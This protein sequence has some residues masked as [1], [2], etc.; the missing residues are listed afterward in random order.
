MS[1]EFNNGDAVAFPVPDNVLRGDAGLTKREWFAG[2]ALQ[3]MG[4]MQQSMFV[5]QN[6]ERISE[7]AKQAFAQA[8]AMI[9]AGEVK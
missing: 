6:Q 2:M 3:G 4:A 5:N 1:K 7:R 8:D 9:E